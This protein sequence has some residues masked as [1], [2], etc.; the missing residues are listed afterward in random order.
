MRDRINQMRYSLESKHKD[1]PNADDRMTDA[2]KREYLPSFEDELISSE[3][4]ALWKRGASNAG[5]HYPGCAKTFALLGTPFA[6]A[7]LDMHPVD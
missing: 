7:S 6:E 5:Y 1:H 2:H 3:E 4:V